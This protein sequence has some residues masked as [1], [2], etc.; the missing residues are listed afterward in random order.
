MDSMQHKGQHS[1]KNSTNNHNIVCNSTRRPT[2]SSNFAA[3]RPPP[4]I[5]VHNKG[6]ATPGAIP[7][8][9]EELSGHRGLDQLPSEQ[10]SHPQ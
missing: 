4:L 1:T 3:E 2:Q 8:S 10:L 9:A 7:V 6:T 5:I